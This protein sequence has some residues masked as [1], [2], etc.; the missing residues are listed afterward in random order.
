LF[1]FGVC[2]VGAGQVERFKP[3]EF[4]EFGEPILRQRLI[5]D[6]E[7][8]QRLEVAQRFQADWRQTRILDQYALHRKAA[9]LA[10]AGESEALTKA[11]NDGVRHLVASENPRRHQREAQK[12]KLH[13]LF[14]QFGEVSPVIR[15]RRLRR[16]DHRQAGPKQ[17]R[18]HDALLPLRPRP[19][20]LRPPGSDH[21]RLGEGRGGT[22]PR[23]EGRPMTEQE[24][25]ACADPAAMLM[26][27]GRLSD[28]K[29]RLFVAACCRRIWRLLP[30]A[31]SRAAVEAAEAY[32]DGRLGLPGL[33]EAAKALSDRGPS[34]AKDAAFY[35][36]ALTQAYNLAALSAAGAAAR[37]TAD[38]GGDASAEKAA[39]ADL[40]R[41]IAGN[42]FRPAPIDPSWLARNGAAADL[43]R[44]IAD[45]QRFRDLPVLAAALAEAGCADEELLTH[46]RRPGGH[47]RGCWALDAVL[48]AAGGSGAPDAEAEQRAAATAELA[49]EMRAAL[50]ETGRAFTQAMGPILRR[51]EEKEKEAGRAGARLLMTFIIALLLAL[52]WGV[53]SR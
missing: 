3:L 18:P 12:I 8:L 49:G 40:L 31:A 36:A 9:A 27:L 13:A 38:D 16:H 41:E 22:M 30:D 47:V 5:A 20:N 52:L 37:A 2:Q 35:A 7:V 17:Q 33:R 32:A 14:R 24:W 21:K 39:Q 26:S 11:G 51:L 44:E 1:Q 46:L 29:Y 15:P 28:R 50:L 6:P 23:K 25:P 34:P 53:L 45:E 48:E 10:P 43:A 4:V 42:P 19:V